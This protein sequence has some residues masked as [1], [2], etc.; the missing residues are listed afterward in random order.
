MARTALVRHDSPRRGSTPKS[1]DLFD[2][3]F[4]DRLNFFRRPVVFWP[5][6]DEGMRVE[7]FTEN[8]TFV[9]RV[10]LAGIDP[11]K[12]VDIT[13]KDHV[14]SITAERREEEKSED[15]EYVRRELRYGAFTR[16]IELPR[17]ATE[18]DVKATYKDGILEVRV[19]MPT[20]QPGTKVSIEKA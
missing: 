11:D 7:E 13:V 20:G 3:F 17:G 15:R 4:D 10:E 19:P 6:F 8:G 16:S 18:A 1:F 9:L 12:D 2:R 14:L 5:E